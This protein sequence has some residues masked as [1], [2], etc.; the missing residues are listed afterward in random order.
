MIPCSSRESNAIGY[1][2]A[3]IQYFFY[4]RASYTIIDRLR[5]PMAAEERKTARTTY[6]VKGHPMQQITEG[7]FMHPK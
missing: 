6:N 3:R 4:I 2:G 5:L 7:L 1:S